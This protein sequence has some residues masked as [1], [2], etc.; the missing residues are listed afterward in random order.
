[1][2]LEKLCSMNLCF[3]F[4][5]I[6]A[7]IHI[8]ISLIKMCC[9]CLFQIHHSLHFFYLGNNIPDASLFHDPFHDPSV[10]TSA[11][12][13]TPTS[14]SSTQTSIAANPLPRTRS[15]RQTKAPTYLGQ[16]HCFLLNQIHELHVHQT[17]TTSYLISSFLS[18]DKFDDEHINFLLSITTSKLP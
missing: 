7:L 17:N 3:L 2:C 4:Q 11:E 10:S 5:K 15:K 9:L 13:I 18:Y 6:R 14:L 1:M 16:Y 12:K 8:L